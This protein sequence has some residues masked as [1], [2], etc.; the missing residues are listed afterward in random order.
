MELQV[1]EM[2]SSFIISLVVKISS[3]KGLKKSFSVHVGMKKG[4]ERFPKTTYCSYIHIS[5]L[6]N[7]L[8]LICLLCLNGITLNTAYT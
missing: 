5:N 8:L 2:I 4:K 7:C 1:E 3:H 6:L